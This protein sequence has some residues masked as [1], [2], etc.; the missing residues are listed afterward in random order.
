MKKAMNLVAACAL[1]NWLEKESII[2]VFS[3]DKVIYPL[4]VQR[5]KFRDTFCTIALPM[6][7]TAFTKLKIS[8]LSRSMG[9][10]Q[11]LPDKPVNP[12]ASD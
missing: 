1:C 9:T 3:T 6:W 12:Q 7:I 5:R 2:I 8:K 4:E 10:Q 11:D